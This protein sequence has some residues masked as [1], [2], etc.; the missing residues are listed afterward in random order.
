MGWWMCGGKNNPQTKGYTWYQVGSER[1]ARF[2]Y[3]L[4]S[5]NLSELI[6]GVRMEPADKLSDHGSTWLELGKKSKKQSKGF[7][8]FNNPFLSD[9]EFLETTNSLIRDTIKEYSVDDFNNVDVV[10]SI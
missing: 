4:T 9:P 6:I 3:F 8:R 2:D 1:R 7:W 10:D 5:T